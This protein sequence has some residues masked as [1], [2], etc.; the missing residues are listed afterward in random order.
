MPLGDH[1]ALSIGFFT[2][3]LPAVILVMLTLKDYDGYYK[4][5]H[6][7]ILLV[8]GL[9]AGVPTALIYYWTII[10]LASVMA[11]IALVAIFIIIAVYELLLLTIILSM[12]RFGAKYDLTYYGVTLSGTMA[13]V[14]VMFSIYLFFRSIDVSAQAILSMAFFIPTM[15]M[16]YITLGAMTGFGIFRGEFFKYGLRVVIIKTIFNVF[17]I[18]WFIGFLFWTERGWEWM[19]IGL[20]FG[21]IGYYYTVK[22]LLPAALPKKMQEHRRRAR[23]RAKFEA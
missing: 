1:L 11:I 7:F 4:D 12:K 5:E 18:F 20:V 19:A 16:L 10:Y 15:P 13:G 22:D 3:I 14:I 21:L 8:F 17:L 6:F 23:R 2:G 9:V